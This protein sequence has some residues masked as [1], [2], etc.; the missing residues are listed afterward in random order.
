MRKIGVFLLAICLCGLTACGGGTTN[1]RPGDEV[2][3]EVDP[4]NFGKIKVGMTKD[5]VEA[6]IGPAYSYD[7]QDNGVIGLWN[8]PGGIKLLLFIDKA[9]KVA[10][11]DGPP[12]GLAY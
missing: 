1:S 12:K 7:P 9:G 11:I 10:S 3:N 5:Q 4:A 6:L 8:K 2:V